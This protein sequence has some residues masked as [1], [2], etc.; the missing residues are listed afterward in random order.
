MYIDDSTS[1]LIMAFTAV[2]IISL[3]HAYLDWRIT[4][5]AGVLPR[6]PD[7]SA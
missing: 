3:S 4:W 6:Y 5:V 7:Y 1:A 2:S